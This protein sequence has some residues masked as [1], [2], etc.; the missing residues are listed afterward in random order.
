MSDAAVNVR[1]LIERDVPEVMA[2]EEAA[3]E[4]PWAEAE[5]L[6]TLRKRNCVGMVAEERP[7]DRVLGFMVY[8][9]FKTH[10]ILHDLAVRPD[11]RRKGVGTRLA[12]RLLEKLTP[13]G[14]VRVVV[15]VAEDNLDAQLFFRSLGFLAVEIER[16]PFK[17]SDRDAY[18]M[19][20]ALAAAP[21]AVA[22]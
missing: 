5:M 22:G 7:A 19:E 20:Y 11:C 6:R 2:I 12:R 4:H 1:W 21:G 13:K 17:T 3:F 10:V 9:L 16:S 8:E 14:I 18:R 15:K